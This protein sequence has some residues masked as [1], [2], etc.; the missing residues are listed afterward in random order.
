MLHYHCSAIH[1]LQFLEQVKG[2]N[3]CVTFARPANLRFVSYHAQSIMLDN[4]AFSFWTRGHQTDWNKY[5]TWVEPFLYHPHFAI[6]FDIIDGDELDNKA[7]LRQWPHP[8][9]FSFPVWHL[10]ASLDYLQFLLDNYPR[11]AFGSSGEYNELGSPKW[12]TRLDQ[13]F[14]LISRKNY[15]SSIHMLR[16]MEQAGKGRWPFASA[17]SSNLGRNFEHWRVKET[18]L[19]IELAEK[20]KQINAQNIHYSSLRPAVGF[21]QEESGNV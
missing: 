14:S 19:G 12:R 8:K 17:D 13:A 7:L 20:A 15:Y 21:F 3:F 10:G 16:A 11:V 6:I 18:S 1:P 4:G 5:Y 9:A 2:Q